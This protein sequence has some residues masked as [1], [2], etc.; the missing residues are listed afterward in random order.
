MEECIHGDIGSVFR[1]GSKEEL[2][3]QRKSVWGMLRAQGVCEN[4]GSPSLG[5][6]A[7]NER[8]GFFRQDCQDLG[9][10]RSSLFKSFNTP[11][12]FI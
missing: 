9:R 11:S 12:Q 10:L 4:V 7:V 6:R 2:D 3:A 5:F 1:R 8:V